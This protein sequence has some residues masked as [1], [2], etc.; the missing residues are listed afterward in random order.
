[1]FTRIS[2]QNFQ[3]RL[4]MNG[5]KIDR[6]E[7]MKMLGVWLAEDIGDWGKKYHRNLQKSFH[8]DGNAV[9]IK[10]SWSTHQRPH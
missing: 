3:T 1:M 5:E 2:N 4:T 10:I 9:K 7:Y 8:K 6:Q